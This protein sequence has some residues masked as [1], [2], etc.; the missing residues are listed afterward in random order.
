YVRSRAILKA[1]HVHCPEDATIE[2]HMQVCARDWLNGLWTVSSFRKQCGRPFQL[3]VF[4]DRSVTERMQACIRHHC[5][6]ADVLPFDEQVNG[7]REYFEPRHPELWRL[8]ASKRFFTL[9]K[10]MD[11]YAVR[12]R[13]VV[14]SIDPDVLFFAP[15]EELLTHEPATFARFNIPRTDTD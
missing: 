10:V 14:L 15:P 13:D 8:R 9:P 11:S 7:V 2:V 5:V 3:V 1:P 6:G 12:R 4:C